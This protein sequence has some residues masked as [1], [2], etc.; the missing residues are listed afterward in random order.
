MSCQVG[1]P[2]VEKAKT[3]ESEQ[4]VGKASNHRSYLNSKKI[5]KMS[6]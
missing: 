5:I 3:I 1:K 2:V 4:K 6:M